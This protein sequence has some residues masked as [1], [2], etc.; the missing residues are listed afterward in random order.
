M[1]AGTMARR[2]VGNQS[3]RFKAVLQDVTLYRKIKDVFS[4][5][6]TLASVVHSADRANERPRFSGPLSTLS[7]WRLSH[8]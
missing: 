2:T 1:T 7:Q 5:L 3:R 6:N 4:V 8:G